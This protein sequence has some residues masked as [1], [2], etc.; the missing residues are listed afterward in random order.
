MTLRLIECNFTFIRVHVANA[1]WFIA[2]STET[3]PNMEGGVRADRLVFIVVPR[4]QA[5]GTNHLCEIDELLL[6]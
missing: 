1:S 3:D 5:F 6:L 2:L 4:R